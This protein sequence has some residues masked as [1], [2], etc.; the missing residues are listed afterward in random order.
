MVDALAIEVDE[1][2]G[3]LRYASGSC[4]QALIRGSPNEET[5]LQ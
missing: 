5:Q 4:K 3:K 2:R 1:G